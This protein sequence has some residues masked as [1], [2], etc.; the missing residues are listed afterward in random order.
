MKQFIIKGLFLLVGL[1]LLEGLVACQSSGNA[2]SAVQMYLDA[3]VQ[4]DVNRMINL[5]CPEWEAQAR[6]EA[7]TFKAMKAQ[8][9][10][11]NCE[12]NGADGNY[13]LVACQGKIVTTYQGETREWNLAE[14]KFKLVLDDGEWR[15][16]GY[17]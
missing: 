8:I 16:C 15:M 7:S 12:E 6:I 1:L 14:H 2:S 11:L 9:E 5:S 10:G 13:T 4:S 3:R 17:E